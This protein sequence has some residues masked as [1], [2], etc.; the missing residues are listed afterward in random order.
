MLVTS[1]ILLISLV[2]LVLLSQYKNLFQGFRSL[3]SL[4]VISH[5]FVFRSTQCLTLRVGSSTVKE[6]EIS[7]FDKQWTQVSSLKVA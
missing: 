6:I 7:Y 1:R 4:Q 5:Y 2:L 3:P